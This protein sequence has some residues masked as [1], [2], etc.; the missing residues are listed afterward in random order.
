[1]TEIMCLA[2][3]RARRVSHTSALLLAQRSLGLTTTA[4]AAEHARDG[5]HGDQETKTLIPAEVFGAETIADHADTLRQRW[6]LRTP[7][8]D[9]GNDRSL[10]VV[11]LSRALPFRIP[12]SK[13]PCQGLSRELVTV[14]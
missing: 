3:P 1:M 7:A 12:F 4:L 6:P 9:G 8:K 14:T 5:Q 10:G 2:P 13:A 11:D